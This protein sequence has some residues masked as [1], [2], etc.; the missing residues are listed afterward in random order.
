MI[1]IIFVIQPDYK[2]GDLNDAVKMLLNFNEIIQLD[3]T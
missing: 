1:L 3:L 2:R